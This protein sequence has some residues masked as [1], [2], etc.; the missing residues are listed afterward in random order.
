MRHPD[1]LDAARDAFK[2]RAGLINPGAAHP[3]AFEIASSTRMLSAIAELCGAQNSADRPLGSAHNAAFAQG[4]ASSD[5][6]MLFADVAKSATILQLTG[7]SAHRLICSTRQ[8]RDFNPTLFPSADNRV[9]MEEIEE[10]GEVTSVIVVSQTSGLTSK[11]RTFGAN[12]FVSEVAIKNDDVGAIVGMFGNIGATS[13]RREAEMVYGLIESNPILADF[14]L[15]FHS[16][17]GNI[18]AADLDAAGLAAA[19]AALRKQPLPGG[20]AADLM[21]DTIVVSPEMELTALTLIHQAG[22]KISVISAPWIA[23]GRWYLMANPSLSPVI[24]L[25]RLG[26][27]PDGVVVGPA[28]DKKAQTRTGVMMAVRVDIGV[29]ALGRTGII[30]GGL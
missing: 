21:A 2:L 24:G 25:L 29:V 4:L 13:A 19:M 26:S 18:V 14:E 20:G 8:V 1:N 17:H 27:V 3:N 30:K 15:M 12:V 16:D 10:N 22:L 9:D 23:A 6:K 7:H 28:R 5:F 11:L